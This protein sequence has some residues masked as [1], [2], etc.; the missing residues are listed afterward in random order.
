MT[1]N[2]ENISTANAWAKLEKT[3]DKTLGSISERHTE[4]H[5]TMADTISRISD[6]NKMSKELEE[7]IDKDLD[8]L[9]NFSFD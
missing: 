3:R 9:L 2:Y 1:Q 7:C 4:F 8:D 6:N 5:K